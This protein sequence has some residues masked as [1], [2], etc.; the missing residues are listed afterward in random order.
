MV[1]GAWQL[2]VTPYRQ[3]WEANIGLGKQV[4]V[5]GVGVQSDI[6]Q[7]IADEVAIM[8]VTKGVLVQRLYVVILIKKK[9][10]TVHMLTHKVVNINILVL[11]QHNLINISSGLFSIAG[12]AEL[13]QRARRI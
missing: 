11:T 8:L 2:S 10:V 1:C 6:F 7:V 9:K 12:I 13:L 3:A 4:D 5:Q